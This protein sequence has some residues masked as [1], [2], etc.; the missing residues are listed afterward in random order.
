M[1]RHAVLVANAGFSG[2]VG[3]VLLKSLFIQDLSQEM[4]KQMKKQR[5]RFSLGLRNS[6][7]FHANRAKRRRALGGERLEHRLL[8]AADFSATQDLEFIDPEMQR[9]IEYRGLPLSS[10]FRPNL[11]YNALR[12]GDTNVDGKSTA[13]DLLSVVNDLNAHGSR[14]ITDW[15]DD[16]YRPDINND[17]HITHHGLPPLGWAIVIRACCIRFSGRCQFGVDG[18]C[19]AGGLLGPGR[20]GILL[21]APV[22][23]ILKHGHKDT[24]ERRT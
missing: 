17:R 24:P 8:L 2:L 16:T 12:P 14:Q 18:N 5:R 7:S 4:K 20:V 19:S 15:T 23:R 13:M 9:L 6:G 10:E 3:R 22:L 21:A 1:I 11:A